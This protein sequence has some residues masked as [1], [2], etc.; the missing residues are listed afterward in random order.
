LITYVVDGDYA[1]VKEEYDRAWS[2]FNNADSD[3]VEIAI[4]LLNAAEEKMQAVIAKS[5]IDQKR[6]I[7]YAKRAEGPPEEVCKD[8]PSRTVLPDSSKHSPNSCLH[9]SF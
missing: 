9:Q 1:Q 6:R 8:R 7:D 5:A 3:H 2:N 4:R